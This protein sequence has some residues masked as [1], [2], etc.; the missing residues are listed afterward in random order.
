MCRPYIDANNPGRIFYIPLR[1]I[2]WSW[3]YYSQTEA[4]SLI[5][6]RVFFHQEYVFLIMVLKLMQ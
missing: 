4:L 3:E 2:A 5:N 1:S 6:F